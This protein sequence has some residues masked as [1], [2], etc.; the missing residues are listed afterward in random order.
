MR[1]FLCAF[2]EFSL[3]IPMN[4]VSSLTLYTEETALEYNGESRNTYISLPRLFNLPQA[5]IRHGI[6]LKYGNEDDN[7]AENKTILLTTEITCE[8]EI[9]DEEIYPLPKVFGGL[10]FSTLFSGIQFDSRPR[11]EHEI[12]DAAG[13]PVLLL[14]T[15][16]L[17]EPGLLGNWFP[18]SR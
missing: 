15:S 10:R 17:L 9:P 3:A 16:L 6:I 5:F 4:T 7:T 1:V 12:S 8:T 14:D 11:R 13:N 18:R 2:G